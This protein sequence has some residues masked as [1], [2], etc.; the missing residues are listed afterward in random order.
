[1]RCSS[2]GCACTDVLLRAT[3]DSVGSAPLLHS[4][5]LPN[6][7]C[8]K[9]GFLYCICAKCKS[10]SPAVR[11]Y[12]L[13]ALWSEPFLTTPRFT[14]WMSFLTANNSG[15]DAIPLDTKE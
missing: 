12:V 6:V 1:M 8:N 11:N 3:V 9:K 4:T 15:R 13:L 10:R 2:G 14:L 7:V 5:H